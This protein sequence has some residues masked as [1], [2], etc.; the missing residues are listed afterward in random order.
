MGEEGL[1][2][3]HT[4]EINISSGYSETLRGNTKKSHLRIGDEVW[5]SEETRLELLQGVRV[6]LSNNSWYVDG[7]PEAH[8]KAACW[9][10]L[11]RA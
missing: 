11:G 5:S 1:W 6:A 9:S 2:I 4:P 10:K 3:F 8:E 7:T